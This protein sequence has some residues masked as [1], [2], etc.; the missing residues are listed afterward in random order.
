MYLDSS[1]PL[2]TE[3]ARKSR[4]E[5]IQAMLGSVAF[6]LVAHSK[7]VNN[8]NMAKFVDRLEVFAED[9]NVTDYKEPIAAYKRAYLEGPKV[10][11]GSHI[12]LTPSKEG[13]DPV[14]ADKDMGL[15]HSDILGGLIMQA[16]LGQNSDL[17]EFR[18]NVFAQLSSGKPEEVGKPAQVHAEAGNSTWGI[19]IIVLIIIGIASCICGA[20]WWCFRK[21]TAD[22][23]GKDKF[24]ASSR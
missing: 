1:H 8:Q 21:R 22:A 18:D 12:V 5:R 20:L 4:E 19:I 15:I 6:H 13:V 2:W 9:A 16:Y 11:R 3:T 23:A 10:T 7:W 14:I 24:A 17:P